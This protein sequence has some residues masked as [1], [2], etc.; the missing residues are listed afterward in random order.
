MT[1]DSHLNK[2][3]R[4]A[5]FILWCL[6]I[7]QT[8]PRQHLLVIEQVDGTCAWGARL[9]CSMPKQTRIAVGL[10][11]ACMLLYTVVFAVHLTRAQCASRK[12]LYQNL[13]ITNQVYQIQRRL[14]SVVFIVVLGA[15]PVLWFGSRDA[16]ANYA[17]TWLG[18]LPIL[19]C[20]TA[21]SAVELIMCQ[22]RVPSD[23]A[24][25]PNYLLQEFS[26]TSQGM[27]AKLAERRRLVAA[28]EV[29][30]ELATAP[31]F[32]MHTAIKTLYWSSLIYHDMDSEGV[33][34]AKD[35]SEV[36]VLC[37]WVADV[38]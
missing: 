3:L 30:P 32:N 8:R 22:P 20:F 17:T 27:Q 11:V 29:A 24:V 16:C 21:F 23:G 18:N 15:L 5:G 19:L 10:N 25:Q 37:S 28:G 7:E 38:V 13:R 34:R 6:V 4:C 33:P 14:N 1:V 31:M 36:R 12:R 9:Q 35:K 26:W 2:R